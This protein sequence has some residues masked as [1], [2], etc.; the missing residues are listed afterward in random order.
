MLVT[1]GAGFIGSYLSERQLGLFI[2]LIFVGDLTLFTSNLVTY[3]T[4]HN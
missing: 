4:G 2:G 1:G 3:V